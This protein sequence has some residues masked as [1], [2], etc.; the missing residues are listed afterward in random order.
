MLTTSNKAVL[1]II[2]VGL[3]SGIVVGLAAGI[4]GAAGLLIGASLFGLGAAG[5]T[6]FVGF[7]AGA[8]FGIWQSYKISNR[9]TGKIQQ[10][11]YLNPQQSTYATVGSIVAGLVGANL[12]YGPALNVT[13]N[14]VQSV[15]AQAATSPVA[16]NA[17]FAKQA[18]LPRPA[19]AAK[20]LPQIRF[21]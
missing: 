14:V 20:T 18:E 3:A 19:L 13:Y 10:Q 2:G 7:I 15:S 1:K 6:Q 9:I 16:A 17:S 8:A 11:T 4:G 21:G 5:T 12:A